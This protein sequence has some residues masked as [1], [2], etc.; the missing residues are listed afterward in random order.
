MGL[1]S[2][3]VRPQEPVLRAVD[4]AGHGRPEQD[5]RHRDEQDR[6]RDDRDEEQDRGEHRGGLT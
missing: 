1:R 2:G 5:E 3:R 4:E 6:R